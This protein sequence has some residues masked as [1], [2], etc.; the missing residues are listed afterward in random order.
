MLAAKCTNGKRLLRKT[1]SA[2]AGRVFAGHAN[3][4]VVELLAADELAAL[5]MDA[6]HQCIQYTMNGPAEKARSKHIVGVFW[7]PVFAKKSTISKL[8]LRRPPPPPPN[9]VKVGE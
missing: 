4:V 3:S 7:V 2:D 8:L 6:R 5:P 9:D 1:S